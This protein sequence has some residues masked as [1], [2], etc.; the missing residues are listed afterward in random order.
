MNFFSQVRLA[1]L[2]TVAVAMV[3][4]TSTENNENESGET[5]GIMQVDELLVK[6]EFLSGQTVTFEGV[7]THTCRHGAKKIFLRGSDD[8]KSI[9]V[10]AAQLGAFDP[11]CVNHVV[12]VTGTL[13]EDRIDEAYLKRWEERSKA[14]DAI[15]HGEKGAGCDSE[16]KARGETASTTDGRIKD[17]RDKIAEQVAMGEN[18]YLSFYHVDATSYSIED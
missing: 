17:F 7:C 12:K 3:A 5:A 15:E 11:A 1:M 9:R 10:E 6:A 16:K 2:A 4:C 8:T 14:A 13:V 18:P